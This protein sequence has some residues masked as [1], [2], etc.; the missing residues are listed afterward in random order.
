[1]HFGQRVARLG[2][3]HA[4]YGGRPHV[5]Q[6]LLPIAGAAPGRTP[7]HTLRQSAGRSKVRLILRPLWRTWGRSFASC[8]P[9][10]S[11]TRAIAARSR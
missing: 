10:R 5:S 4:G 2:I 7:R 8:V 11:R 3:E 1:M 6:E 9:N